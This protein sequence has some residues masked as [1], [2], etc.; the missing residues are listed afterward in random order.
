MPSPTTYARRSR[1][2]TKLALLAGGGAL[3][4]TILIGCSLWFSLRGHRAEA[5][6]YA[7]SEAQASFQ[8][9]VLF[10]R[11]I[12]LQ[13]GV[14]VPP[15]DA[16]PPNPY[17]ADLP[18]RDV[19]TTTG[20]TLT[21]INPAYLTRM[22]HELGQT[23]YGTRAHL[24]SLQPLRPENAA[25][26]WEAAALRAFEK[27][28]REVV[29]VVTDRGEPALRLMRP[30]V[31][32]TSCL[33]CHAAQGYR[34]GDIRGGLSTSVALAPYYAAA[35]Q[36]DRTDI[37]FHALLLV[38][39]L[40]GIV[41]GHHFLR[42]AI[43]AQEGAHLALAETERRNRQ[44]VE[45]LP[46]VAVTCTL[47]GTVTYANPA[48]QAL[49]GRPAERSIGL[50]FFET[51]VPRAQRPAAEEVF[52]RLL[53][54]RDPSTTSVGHLVDHA[55][56][57]RLVSWVH[58]L[59][60]DSAGTPVGVTS[61]GEDITTR[62]AEDLHLRLL[63]CAVEQSPAVVVITDAKGTIEYVNARFSA[64]TGY[65]AAEAIGQHTRLLSSGEA[66]KEFYAGLWTTILA[67]QEW[68]GV[69]HNRRKNG[70]LFWEDA[71]ISPVRD[72]S[73]AI[74]R[75]IAIKED[76]TARRHTEQALAESE[77]R[78]RS[79]I[80]HAP[81]AVV[82]HNINQCLYA[83]PAALRL[84]GYDERA[85]VAGI[86]IRLH[87]HPTSL[88][89][90]LERHAHA[91]AG[92]TNPPAE[93]ELR[94]N[95]GSRLTCES[96][97]TR[98]AFNGQPATLALIVD[99]TERRQMVAALEESE[100]RYRT[101]VEVAP[102]AIFSLV[103]GRFTY[104]NPA[105]ARLLGSAQPAALVGSNIWQ[106]V[107]ADALDALTGLLTRAE[108]GAEA[109]ATELRFQRPDR[110]GVVCSAVAVSV[111][112]GSQ[113]A[114]L[115]LASDITER[116]RL[117]DAL[118]ENEARM[119]ETLENTNAGYFLLD[120]HDCL[121]HANSALL[122][123]LDQP[124]LEAARGKPF[125]E[126]LSENTRPGAV[127]FL[128][129]LACGEEYVGGEFRTVR[130]NGSLAHLNFTAHLVRAGGQLTGCEGFV[131]DTTE[132]H[133]SEERYQMLFA[134]MLDGFALHEIVCDAEGRPVDYRYL[135][136][137]PSFEKIIGRPAAALV[138]RRVSEVF[139]RIDEKWIE[140]FGRIAL[141]GTPGRFDDFSA[142]ADRHL[143]VV[144][145][146]PSPG[147][148]ACLVRDITE[149]HRLEQQLL[150]AQKMEAVGQL[151]GGVA[152]DYN[153][154]LV[155]IL[156]NLSILRTEANLRP[157]TVESLQELER[158][159][160][161]AAA[162]TRQ[163]LVFS[164]RQAMQPARI[165]FNDQLDHMLKM[166]RRLLGE[167]IEIE[168]V[169]APDLPPVF[170]DPGMLDQ[171]VMNLCVNARDAMP[172]G[173]RLRISTTPAVFAGPTAIH[174]EAQPGSF[175]ALAVSDTGCGMDPA[176]LR[177]LFEPFFT[178]KEPGKGTGL[179]LA[180]VF[181]IVKQHKGW[182][183]V[184]SAPGKG[185]TFRV[186]LP[187]APGESEPSAPA[188]RPA[189]AATNGTETILLVEDDDVSRQTMS[190][191]LRR[192]GYHVLAARNVAEALALW[193]GSHPPI[194]ALITDIVMPGGHN[195]LE[196]AQ[197]LR[198]TQPDLSI[199]V[200]SGYSDDAARTAPVVPGA[201]YLAKPFDY[202]TLTQALRTSLAHH[203]R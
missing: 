135:A 87:I 171:V 152:H 174:P 52:N 56:A 198:A 156:M 164:R 103:H 194:A 54:G 44:L 134:Q 169:L 51:F 146:Q 7:R 91:A 24:T 157:E 85:A 131:L 145:F 73:G 137:N 97:A 124:S 126:L 82:V 76:I 101:L 179:G 163:L 192:D 28:A 132:A 25:D 136:A 115:V 106:H 30:F 108:A 29:Q 147:R 34:E 176:T 149:K 48:L 71:H 67:G 42:R 133:S 43:R 72:S 18:Q 3:A 80:E 96:I 47:D 178:T 123:M 38:A 65:T 177:R 184:E 22:V 63:S 55:G 148:F 170:A 69:F 70:E 86:D 142:E 193:H 14:Y 113:S 102:V 35:R 138:G 81:V 200:I 129:R 15:T 120:S 36:E 40:G 104:A 144:A 9:D 8:K 58:T 100:A 74:V 92:G 183:E 64:V 127:E 121:R 33:K 11:W 99:I 4:W 90:V 12:S 2:L 185:S 53:R 5:E 31:T 60:S 10:R 62:N 180:T 112:F 68:R 77:Q 59:V 37:F 45:Q 187:F 94:R 173:G 107:H 172:A 16:T 75:F 189:S 165:E 89:S 139:P 122:H 175:M 118:R 195:G 27:G 49:S 117:E 19:V 66:P 98:I 199:I 26:A 143:E 196:L 84:F 130:A 78:F 162:L 50:N 125:V 150:Q 23:E 141:T 159:A 114:V 109:A 153:N 201:A 128:Q 191:T 105:A 182:I 158:E 13:G 181:S 110:S 17:L 88:D 116:K 203:R 197:Q 46:L 188:P 41:G 6:A 32:E 111:A 167:Q 154:I 61:L 57:D 21:L 168:T 95:D 119:R 39:G 160:K 1:L 20:Q 161:R 151:A 166:L 202:N 190:L 79:L 140:R 186:Y 93:L 83:N 155:A